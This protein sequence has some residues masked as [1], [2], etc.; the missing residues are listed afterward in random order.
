LEKGRGAKG[1]VKEWEGIPPADLRTRPRAQSP[2]STTG[3]TSG[4]SAERPHPVQHPLSGRTHCFSSF[5]SLTNRHL[6]WAF[7][8]FLRLVQTVTLPPPSSGFYRCFE[9]PA[10]SATRPLSS[11]P[12]LLSLQAYLLH[13]SPFTLRTS[14]LLSSR[15]SLPWLLR[16]LE[17]KLDDPKPSQPQELPD[18][19]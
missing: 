5:L 6:G 3:G 13:L 14:H 17:S 15:P 11:H 8:R 7:V 19:Q 16:W 12:T 2:T 1:K 10:S 18:Q 4:C 9:H